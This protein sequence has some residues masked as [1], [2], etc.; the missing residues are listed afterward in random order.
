MQAYETHTDPTQKAAYDYRLN[1]HSQYARDASKTGH[2]EKKGG[3]NWKFDEREMKRRQY[4]N[5]HIRK[6]AK[7]TASYNA[8]AEEK[9]SYNEYK[10]ILFATPLAVALFVMIMK[11]TGP[12]L[13]RNDAASVSA[14]HASLGTSDIKPGD[15]PY[16]FIFGNPSYDDVYNKTL[17]IKNMTGSDAIVCIFSRHKF[18][19]SF[20]V[21]GGFSAEV[22]QLPRTPLDIRYACGHNFNYHLKLPHAKVE[23]GFTKDAYYYRS[24]AELLPAERSEL[25]LYPGINEGFVQID[26]KQFFKTKE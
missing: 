8:K 10:Y 12:V 14:Q 9:K 21:Q 5:E 18:I 24:I 23:G 7:E 20:F 22:P 25:T 16:N 4:Y 15:A 6:Y 19:R 17:L 2:T 1:S 13:P 11:L 3:K 26:E